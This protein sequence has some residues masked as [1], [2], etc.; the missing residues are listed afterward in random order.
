M[1]L[2][3]LGFP[4]NTTN[5]PVLNDAHQKR[6]S[7]KSE[8]KIRKSLNAWL[9]LFSGMISSFRCRRFVCKVDFDDVVLNAQLLPVGHLLS[10]GPILINVN[11]EKKYLLD[12]W[13]QARLHR[14]LWAL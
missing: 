7:K 12:I 6:H 2:R 13:L 11:F 1:T 8:R 4:V 3:I 14:M 9:D 10:R 5:K